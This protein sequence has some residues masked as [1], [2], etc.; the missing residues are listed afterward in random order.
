VPLIVGGDI[1]V[2]GRPDFWAAVANGD[3]DAYLNTGRGTG[4][5][6]VNHAG[7]WA[8]RKQ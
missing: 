7:F 8:Q 3:V 4:R 6:V 1:N 5:K 2:D